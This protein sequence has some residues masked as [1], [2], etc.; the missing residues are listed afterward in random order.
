M[1]RASRI[2]ASIEHIK[3]DFDARVIYNVHTSW[4]FDEK[5]TSTATNYDAAM[6]LANGWFAEKGGDTSVSQSFIVL[7]GAPRPL[8]NALSVSR[9]F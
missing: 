8:W 7:N 3:D 6:H 1:S 2:K 9:N 4:R 5:Y